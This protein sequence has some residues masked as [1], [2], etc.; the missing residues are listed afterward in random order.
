MQRKS[1]FGKTQ[2]KYTPAS[3]MRLNMM[4]CGYE[5]DMYGYIGQEALYNIT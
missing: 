3:Y 2:S 4:L 1:D 5:N